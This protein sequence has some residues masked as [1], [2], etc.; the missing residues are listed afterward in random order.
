MNQYGDWFAESAHQNFDIYP[1]AAGRPPK[2]S[3]CLSEAF[4]DQTKGPK[5]PK[6]TNFK[7]QKHQI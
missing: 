7:H 1:G 2:K 5:A 3:T 6:M 4:S